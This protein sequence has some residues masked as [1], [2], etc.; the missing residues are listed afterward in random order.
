MLTFGQQLQLLFFPFNHKVIYVVSEP[1]TDFS[2]YTV[3]NL[4]FLGLPLYALIR[5]R[6]STQ[7]HKA[8]ELENRE[9]AARRKDRQENRIRRMPPRPQGDQIRSQHQDTKTRQRAST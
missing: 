3:L 4:L 9:Q 5:V 1:F 8:Q 7:E 6:N 2:V